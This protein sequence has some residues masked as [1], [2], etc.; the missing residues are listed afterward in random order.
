MTYECFCQECGE[1]IPLAE[2]ETEEE[3]EEWF[4]EDDELKLCFSCEE[5]TP[6]KYKFTIKNKKN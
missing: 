6:K 3:Q 5:P 1:L 4:N 2:G